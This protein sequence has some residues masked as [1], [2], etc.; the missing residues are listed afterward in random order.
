MPRMV[1]NLLNEGERLEAARTIYKDYNKL[2]SHERI[3]RKDAMEKWIRQSINSVGIP[4]EGQVLKDWEETS[5]AEDKRE[6]KDMVDKTGEKPVFGQNKWRQPNSGSDIL[7]CIIQPYPD[8]ADTARQLMKDDSEGTS[9][10]MHRNFWGRD[11]KFQGHVY[12]CLNRAWSKI[13]CL[14]Y[15]KV[16]KSKI[17]KLLQ[18]FLESDQ[19]LSERSSPFRS[20]WNKNFMMTCFRDRG[21]SGWDSGALK[22]CA[23]LPDN[24]FDEGEVHLID[25]IAP[26]DYLFEGIL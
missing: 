16:V 24:L 18:E 6:K 9:E 21:S 22:V 4:Y 15:H 10:Y 7:C 8:D 3:K 14:D 19:P 26:P 25:M 23:Y 2:S 20:S 11:Y 1:E 13:R 12:C 5:E 17:D